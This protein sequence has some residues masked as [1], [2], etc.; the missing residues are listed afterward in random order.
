[1]ARIDIYTRQLCGH[2]ALA[3]H[4]LGEKGVGFVEHDATFDP[5]LRREMVRRANGAGTFPQIFINGAH[6]G[7]CAELQMLERRG[8]LDDLLAG[9]SQS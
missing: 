3:K 5:E 7:G 8:Q 9:G 6:I 4:L 2:C 1:M